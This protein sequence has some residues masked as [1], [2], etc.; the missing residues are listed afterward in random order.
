[1]MLRKRMPLAGLGVVFL[2][3]AAAPAFADNGFYV[4]ALG[5]ESIFHQD[6]SD[7]DAA[8]V[9]AFNANGFDLIDGT[10][11]LDKTDFAFGGVIG[12]RFFPSFAVEASYI[13]LSKLDYK[14]N[15]TATNGIDKSDEHEGT[16]HSEDGERLP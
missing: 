13:D 12:Y 3:S 2:A 15:G 8:V 5:G 4:G 9:G 7:A 10:S 16:P 11:S 1:M 6:R 14:L